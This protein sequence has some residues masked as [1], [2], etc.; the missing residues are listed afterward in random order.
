M[1][2]H[3]TEDTRAISDIYV[4]SSLVYYFINVSKVLYSYI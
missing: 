2:M 1:H 4:Y 3:E